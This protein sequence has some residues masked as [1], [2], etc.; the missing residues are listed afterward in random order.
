MKRT[1]ARLL[2]S[3]GLTGTRGAANREETRADPRA[4]RLARAAGAAPEP[5]MSALEERRLLFALTVTA[6]AVDPTT[7]LG[8]VGADFGYVLPYLFRDFTPAQSADTQV[9]EPF[10][11]EGQGTATPPGYRFQGSGARLAYGVGAGAALVVG[12][13]STTDLDLRVSISGLGQLSFVYESGFDAVPPNPIARAARSVVLDIGPQNGGL[14]TDPNTGTQVEL[15]L[16]GTIVRRFFGGNAAAPFQTLPDG[17]RRYTLTTANGGFFNEVRFSSANQ[18]NGAYFDQFQIDNLNAFI[19]PPIFNALLAPR[20]WGARV[21]FT[22]PVGASAQ[23][24]D[25]NDRDMQLTTDLLGTG[26]VL[27]VDINKDGVPDFNDGLGRIVF[28]GTDARSNFTMYGL[29][30]QNT[31]FTL[32]SEVSGFF[33]EFES[34]GFGYALTNE[35]PPRV[36]GLPKGSGSVVV[37]SPFVRSLTN[38][39]AYLTNPS[40]ATLISN[41]DLFQ[42]PNQ[43]LFTTNG[44]NI[45]SVIIH[46]AVHGSSR[47]T[48]SVDRLAIGYML[49]SVAVTGD[50]GQ[51]IVASDSGVWVRDDVTAT[52]FEEPMNSTR[53]Q[54]FV[55]R[56]VGEIAIA[57]RNQS[58]VTVQGD[59]NDP[60]KPAIN[61]F[62]HAEREFQYGTG[63]AN[64][65]TLTDKTDVFR[66]VLFNNDFP[67]NQAVA[68]GNSHFRNDSIGSAEY[69]GNAGTAVRITGDL[70]FQDPVN[71]NDDPADVYAFAAGPGSPLTVDVLWSGGFAVTGGYARIVDRDGRVLAATDYSFLSQSRLNGDNNS[72]VQSPLSGFRDRFGF[73]TLGGTKNDLASRFRFEPE[74]TDVYYLVLNTPVEGGFDRAQQ[75]VVTMTGMLP[76]TL[77]SF[78]S[79]ARTGNF[80]SPVNI[81]VLSGSVG[82]IRIGTGYVG[83]EG[84]E[85]NPSEVINT[86]L[87]VDQLLYVRELSVSTPGNLYSIY[88]GSDVYG[89]RNDGS[90][91]PKFTIGGDLGVF[92]TG[93]ALVVGVGTGEGDVLDLDLQVG[94]RIG[95]LD[96]RG[97][98]RFFQDVGSFQTDAE[99]VNVRTGVNGGNGDIGGILVGAFIQGGGFNL[100]TSPGSTID[101]FVIGASGVAGRL[102]S[103]ER[104]QPGINLGAGSDIRFADFDQIAIGDFDNANPDSFY[105]LTYNQALTLIDDSGAAVTIRI[106]DGTAAAAGSSG[107]V[108]VLPVA[109]SRGVAIA[110]IDATLIGGANLRISGTDK[111]VGSIGHISIVTQAG[112]N[113]AAQS[114][115]FIE[116]TTEIDV[117]RIDQTAGPALATISNRT[118]N[119]DLVA[120]DV[121][122][123]TNLTILSGDL[124][125]TQT[126][127]VGPKKIGPFLGLQ[128]GPTQTNGA[129]LGV[130]AG[131]INPANGG[132]ALVPVSQRTS[133]YTGDVTLEDLGS[134]LN[135]YL[136]GIVIR[137]GALT[138]AEIGGAVGDIVL[139][140]GDATAFIQSLIV[141]RDGVTPV[142][143]FDGI[144][145]VIY[146]F[147][148]VR[149]DVG[150]GLRGPGPSPL[151]Q[152]GIFADN[153]IQTIIAG[154]RIASVVMSG[155]ILA[156]NVN[157]DVS[158]PGSGTSIVNGLGPITMT[159][160]RVDGAFFGAATLD[161]WWLSARFYGLVQRADARI[162]R[163]EISNLRLVNSDL[164]RSKVYGALLTNLTV[165]GGAFDAS[166]VEIEG[167]I[168]SIAADEF[169]NSTK[170]GERREYRFNEIR[171]SGDVG[172][173]RTTPAGGGTGGT[174][175][176]NQ[177]IGDMSDLEIDVHGQL[178]TL[179]T[180]RNIVRSKI[181]FD[182]R[183]VSIVA[184]NDLRA[185][186]ITTGR[187]ESLAVTGDIRSS[188]ITTAGAIVSIIAGGS[189]TSTDIFSEGPD[190]RID[191]VQVG[192]FLTGNI[193]A[194]GPIAT[195][196]STGGQIIATITTTDASDGSLGLLSAAGDLQ[197]SLDIARDVGTVTSGGS[198][199]GRGGGGEVLDTLNVRGNLG[200]I[201][202]RGQIY[203]DVRVGGSITGVITIGR[204]VA[205]PGNDLVSR[206]SFR[207]FGRINSFVITGDFDGS[208]ISESGGIGTVLITDGSFRPGNQIV[209]RDGDIVRV[210]ITGGHLMGDIIADGTI[211]AV[212]VLA[213]A[214]GFWGDMGV[215]PNL[216]DAIRFD[217]LRNQLPP[218]A[219]PVPTFQG[220][221]IRAG[222]N[223]GLVNIQKG[224]MWESSIVAGWAIGRIYV[225]GVILN[226]D[227]T[228]GLGG[229][230]IVA[231][232]SIDT[233]EVGDFAGGLIVHAG[234]IDLG[235]DGRP[236]GVGVNTDTVKWG[237]INS[238]LFRKSTG[239]VT[240]SAGMVAGFD[241]VYNTGDDLL[242]NGISSIGT[243]VVAGAPPTQSSVYA[244]N[245]LGF[246]SPGLRRGGPGQNQ[247]NTTLVPPI[248]P[249]TG[250]IPAAGLEITTATGERARIFF[251]GPGRA[252][253]SQATQTV[254][255]INSTSA[256]TIVV[257]AITGTLTNFSVLT[258]DGSSLGLMD[259]Q[260][261][262]FGNSNFFADGYVGTMRF[263]YIQ[264]SGVIGS[265]MDITTFVSGPMTSGSMLTN[266]IV[267][268]TIFGDYGTLA[269]ATSKLTA[270]AGGSITITGRHA[271]IVN[272]AR[273][274]GSL[275]INGRVDGGRSRVG[276]F[277]GSYVSGAMFRAGLSTG[278]GIGSVVVNGTADDSYIYAGADLGSDAAFGGLGDAA[279]RVTDGALGPVTINGDFT[280]SD[281]AAGV[282]RGADGFLGTPDD[283]ADD[284]RSSI[285]NVIVTG[286]NVG[287]GLN[288]ESYRVSS[289]GT[290][291]AVTVGGAA[292]NASGN[293]AVVRVGADPFPVEVA[294]LEV[295][296]DSNIWT[297]AIVFNQPV[298]QSTIS[299]ALT[300]AEVRNGGALTVG[301]AEGSDYTLRYDP[302][303]NSA[304]VTFSPDVT[305]RDLP[306]APGVPGPGTYRFTIDAA[307]LRGQSQR[308]RL[309]G[310]SDGQAAGDTDDYIANQVVGDAGDKGGNGFIG[311]N[312][313]LRVDFYPAADLNLVMD[314]PA[315]QDG[316]P[317]TNK[318]YTIKGAIGDH[319]DSDPVFFR[320]GGDVDLYQIFL[321]AGQILR[322]GKLEGAASEAQRVV[323][324]GNAFNGT[325]GLTPSLINNPELLSLPVQPAGYDD[326]T[327]RDEYLVRETGTYFVIVAGSLTD[328][329]SSQQVNFGDNSVYNVPPEGA[330]TGTYSFTI[331]VFD[332]ADTGFAGDTDSGDGVVVGTPPSASQFGSGD[333][334]VRGSYT[335]TLFRDGPTEATWV[336]SGS[337]GGG[338]FSERRAGPDGVFAS[339]ATTGDDQIVSFVAGAIGQG[340]ASGVPSQ[341]QS[342][343]DVYRLNN[344]DPIVPGTRIRATMRLN[345]FGSNLG[346]ITPLR[347][348]LGE[349]V[350]FRIPDFRGAVQMA[351]FETTSAT[352]VGDAQLIAAPSAFKAVSGTPKAVT[353]S[354]LSNH[355]GYDENGDFFI[356]FIAPPRQ[357]IAGS[358]PARLALYVQGVLRSDYTL[359]IRTLGVDTYSVQPQ[360][361]F[362]E[363]RGG[364]INWIEAGRN[365]T[366]SLRSY[367]TSGVGFSGFISGVAVDTY[368]LNNTITALN[369]LF[370]D[371]GVNVVLS[372]NVA[373]FENQDFSTLVLTGSNEPPAF[374]DNQTF[375]ASQ[376][377][378]AFNADRNDQAVV[379]I[380]ALSVLQY[381]PGKVGIDQFVQSLTAASARRIGELLGLRLQEVFVSPA[382]T[383]A[384]PVDVMASDSV[385]NI[386]TAGAVY[387]FSTTARE[388]SSNTDLLGSTNFF[389]G[390]QADVSLLQRI[391]PLR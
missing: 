191:L 127:S 366:T 84:A 125:R 378:D 128:F 205:L 178:L 387:R 61:Y 196:T 33:S 79:G 268:A 147:D 131:S 298:T 16:Q 45:G 78:R 299:P 202:A 342:D 381:N 164:L 112:A 54:I 30:I 193:R 204:V 362:I 272:V 218:G 250:L 210:A 246:T 106:A 136:N 355:Y 129:P 384:P 19:P 174:G 137:T 105:T 179:L 314:G 176:K 65:G 81:S 375:G 67:S 383:T 330:S 241:G 379:F 96:W 313:G 276:L 259:I 214:N 192:Q 354:D 2:G 295:G 150:D 44:A 68:F 142:G 349:N 124:G 139:Q 123:L 66:L 14:D 120:V 199:G 296:E 364:S 336:V 46:G 22:G 382:G 10:D 90:P 17:T 162:P 80:Q 99:V 171:A 51:Y 8:T 185:S 260:P 372:T 60:A 367:T 339:G 24:F 52:T 361:I 167:N 357:G 284:G 352:G 77:G 290:I 110:R 98:V 141:N 231:G 288:S 126:N 292:F 94:G 55:G 115:I 340:G 326:I 229:S 337:N 365:I 321:R 264:T 273:N 119:G 359:E 172:T 49:G 108:R 37:G 224:S 26:D 209:A 328:T 109:G 243:V 168:I 373:Q 186:T 201:T 233:I 48:G 211:F 180:A 88:A 247:S 281:V 254:N 356:E 236:G 213:A 242:A 351:V 302:A 371:A 320:T 72:S 5:M 386:P 333:T 64:T 154:G 40:P 107:R 310:N 183:V 148:I 385:P 244:D 89:V 324:S 156:S 117:L 47:F 12:T 267:A 169:R 311:N 102:G 73:F 103:I 212:E 145:G 291:G 158:P 9:V 315:S 341:V 159:N 165:A 345:E 152:A 275:T 319:P 228:P 297:A 190:G 146:A 270:G 283:V 160:A 368:V 15:L 4:E 175:G 29:N 376:R 100:R 232:D 194:S 75:Y 151:A 307:I 360:N 170:D 62:E 308:N 198:V 25:L 57:G 329:G 93:Q 344:G 370:R 76:T 277:L 91:G 282:S 300:V 71:A 157:L 278:D 200:S 245:G 249:A 215:N 335:Y 303:S 287:S 347:E 23:F 85:T 216:S 256:S 28:S 20:A 374:F 322:L 116:G 293:F 135:G 316:L 121:L 207:A 197:V 261:S 83:G 263:G 346:Y 161:A 220:P 118:P 43:G 56:T 222:R 113:N 309:D 122:G 181:D 377:A 318:P 153:D 325:A 11:D 69:V 235:R 189:I 274:L 155:L 332:D 208:I 306:Q 182:D 363:T 13:G 111:G 380:P 240:I 206:A 331:E 87:G 251:T 305:R 53:S 253:W 97:A 350:V 86:A 134:P 3:L 221:Q 104:R 285:G 50:M 173:I 163:G 41:P 353:G 31:P 226:D 279:D 312:G 323:A 177:V 130:N 143:R 327:L 338:I 286:G 317:D 280:R 38:P 269:P 219:T 1:M 266:F 225:D 390:L 39:T 334:I 149:I 343:V 32:P 70:G 262:I 95:L 388:I 265:G 195:I 34:A 59:L 248:V 252:F 36:I 255:I 184:L 101:R 271:G 237:R 369:T 21:S 230:F 227:I 188:S 223:I 257:Q 238:I 92:V 138:L 294:R 358:V 7:G 42:A 258:N 58:S 132:G 289:T 82:A 74:Y 217:D 133:D 18:L 140:G 63:F 239:A 114:S 348:R 391:L 166:S 234:I 187:L 27:R 35:T 6:D 301:L 389:L 304:L 203:A 144:V